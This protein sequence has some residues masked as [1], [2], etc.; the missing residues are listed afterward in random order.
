MKL[1]QMYKEKMM[2]V[3]DTI[4]GDKVDKQKLSMKLDEIIESRSGI[5]P[6]LWMRNLYTTEHFGVQ[7]NDI[8]DIIHDNSLCVEANNTL[9]YSFEKV[10]SPIPKILI[11]NKAERNV[12]KKKMLAFKAEAAKMKKDGSFYEGC[13]ADLGMRLEDGYQLK[14][15]TFM[16]SIYGVQGQRGSI[17]YAPDTAGAVTSQGRELIGEMTWTIERLLYGTLHFFSTGELFSYLDTIKHEMHKDSPLFE[18][19]TYWPTKEDVQSQL[20]K[21]IH[22]TN[23]M[24]N[25]IEDIS[26][27]LLNFMDKMDEKERAYYYYKN[28]MF[29]LIS[30][31]VKIFDLFDSMIKMEKPLMSTARDPE[32]NPAFDDYK[33]ILDKICEILDEF[34]IM[35]MSTPKR[36]DKYKS[37][38]RRGIIVSDTDS[39]IINLHPYV[40]NLYKLHCLR[41][42][43]QYLG[44]HVGFHNEQLDFKLVNI[45][46]YICVHVTEVAGDILAKG[47]NTPPSLRKWIEM[48]NE[49]L[50]KKLVMYSS[51]KKNY[52]V[53]TRLQEGKVIDDCPATGIKLNASGLH[54]KVKSDMMD[55]IINDILKTEE[56]N[57]ITIMLKLKDIER[58][59]ISSIQNGDLTLG[60]KARYSGPNGY[61]TGVY[62]NDSGRAAYIWNLLYPN[63]RISTGDYGYVF[64]TTLFTKDD[65]IKKVMPKYPE[66]AKLLLK[67][68]FDN[69]NEPK[70]AQFGLKCIM[71]PQ[72]ESVKSLPEWLIPFVDYPKITQK[73]LGPLVTLLPS[74]GLKLSAVSSSKQTYSPLISF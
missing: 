61:K 20:V 11:R 1:T 12:H 52:V 4:Y 38:R 27:S 37:K 53:N 30:K 48:K 67:Y 23:G 16:N 59:I 57:P 17:I 64:N 63:K 5:F 69:P 14:I 32:N 56:I 71:I 36:T 2:S 40:S 31:N 24:E 25:Y 47:G 10:E 29:N 62:S 13:P 58:S 43:K 74:I 19:I 22:K 9:T 35:R 44:E 42:N 73:H 45:M 51:V 6:T 3:L 50:F 65:V 39:V 8:M 68:I 33:P 46:S 18:Y 15:K 54:P 60:K 28:N 66:E 41:N 72:S 26:I 21:A 7:L 70:L 55:V 49:F 34:V